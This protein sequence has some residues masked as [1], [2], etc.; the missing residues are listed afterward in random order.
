MAGAGLRWVT[1][2][3]RLAGFF[4]AGRAG[5]FATLREAFFATGRA[6]LFASLRETFFA[7]LRATF[8]AALRAVRLTTFFGRFA[9]FLPFFFFVL[10]FLAMVKCLLAGRFNT[11]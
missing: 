7:T 5:F 10:D 3:R 2:R 9:T 11:N 6:A 4:A 1:G 8:F